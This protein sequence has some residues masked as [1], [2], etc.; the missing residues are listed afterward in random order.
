M[1]ADRTKTSVKMDAK[2][3]AT[4]LLNS[5]KFVTGVYNSL[6]CEACTSDVRRALS[7]ILDDEHAI[8]NDI[9]NEMSKRGW[10]VTQKAEE[11]KLSNAKSKFGN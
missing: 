1:I 10:Y 7:S 8:Q 6:L 3:V 4:D 9:F 11:N 5:Q 2:M